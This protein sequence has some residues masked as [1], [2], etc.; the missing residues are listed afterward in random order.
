M[1]YGDGV[2][3]HASTA[4]T[5]PCDERTS[6]RAI[7]SIILSCMLP[8]QLLPTVMGLYP[9]VYW[10]ASFRGVVPLLFAPT[11]LRR[12]NSTTLPQAPPNRTQVN[13]L[14]TKSMMRELVSQS[15]RHYQIER[16]LQEKEFPNGIPP[17]GVYTATYVCLT[18]LMHKI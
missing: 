2:W 6:V 16:V 13:M 5:K 18:P 10:S 8:S 12:Y 7:T 4:I 1:L 14:A 3:I 9:A 17:L 11:A 15:S